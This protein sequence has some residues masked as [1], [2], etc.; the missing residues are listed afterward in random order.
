MSSTK[1]EKSSQANFSELTEQVV[2]IS[3]TAKA[4]TG[5]TKLSFSATVV[6]GDK[7]GKIGCGSG[8]A[9]D[10][11]SALRKATEA[12]KCSMISINLCNNTLQH[13]VIGKFGATKVF[14]RPAAE[15]TGIIA[16]GAMRAVFEVLGVE[17]VL[18]KCI[19]STNPINVVK[20]TIKGLTEMIDPATVAKKRGIRISD[21]L[22]YSTQG[23]A[24]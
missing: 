12:A 17:N 14:M 1:K 22:S 24:K 20:A 21:V 15:G 6:V 23:E 2:S 19:K 11:P 13:S 8:K 5:G 10:V 18:S 3:R 9:P 4:T 7:N 16:G